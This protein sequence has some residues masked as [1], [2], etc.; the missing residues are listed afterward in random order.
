MVMKKLVCVYL[1]QMQIRLMVIL[2]YWEQAEVCTTYVIPIFYLDLIVSHWRFEIRPLVE[3][4]Q[5]NN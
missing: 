4:F 5:P 1:V 3:L 2:N